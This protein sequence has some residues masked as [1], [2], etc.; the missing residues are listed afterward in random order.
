MKSSTFCFQ[1]ARVWSWDWWI[2][3]TRARNGKSIF[4]HYRDGTYVFIILSSN[5]NLCRMYVFTAWQFI[6]IFAIVISQHVTVSQSEFL[7][8]FTHFCTAVK[9]NLR[10]Y[11]FCYCWI[12]KTDYM[13]YV[14][15]WNALYCFWWHLHVVG[16]GYFFYWVLNE[17][18]LGSIS[19]ASLILHELLLSTVIFLTSQF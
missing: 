5:S 11:N 7:F 3:K 19:V 15:F 9:K 13:Y 18:I 4:C 2:Y 16:R 14:E 6:Y 8:S 10:S 12:T 1:V 17:N